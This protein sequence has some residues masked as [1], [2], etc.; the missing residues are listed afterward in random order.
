MVMQRRGTQVN[1]FP[2]QRHPVGLLLRQEVVAVLHPAVQSRGVAEAY[3]CQIR[4][5]FC[6][7]LLRV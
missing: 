2:A 1:P 6:L 4:S 7:D 3:G 5:R